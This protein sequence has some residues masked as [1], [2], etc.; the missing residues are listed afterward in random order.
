[1]ISAFGVE[2]SEI[3]KADKLPWKAKTA[4]LG[5]GAGAAIGGVAAHNKK[6][7]G[8]WKGLAGKEGLKPT[9]TPKQYKAARQRH[10]KLAEQHRKDK[11]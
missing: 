3:S 2:H 7:T 11:S 6:T 10:L 9:V 4:A 1:M 5:I 8:S